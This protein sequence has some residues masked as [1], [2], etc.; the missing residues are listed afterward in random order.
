MR[1]LILGGLG[2]SVATVIGLIEWY[3]R[4][5]D[6]LNGPYYMDQ[7]RRFAA[8]QE[9]GITPLDLAPIQPLTAHRASRRDVVN[10]V[11]RFHQRVSGR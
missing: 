5:T 11:N 10:R 9:A 4:R 1:L 7:L 8:N 3:R 2:V 6:R